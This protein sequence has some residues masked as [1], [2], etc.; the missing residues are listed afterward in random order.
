MLGYTSRALPAF[1]H[2]SHPHLALPP[3]EGLRDW[4]ATTSPAQQ[5]AI[6]SI[7]APLL[8]QLGYGPATRSIKG[9]ALAYGERARYRLT[10][11]GGIKQ[12][13]DPRREF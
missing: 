8:E 2:P 11:L 1:H 7:C 12:R 9:L 4:T 10:H 5:I 13:L 6:E 3:T